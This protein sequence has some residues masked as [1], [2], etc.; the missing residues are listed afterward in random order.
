MT[1]Y[2]DTIKRLTFHQTLLKDNDLIKFKSVLLAFS[3]KAS[4]PEAN[5]ELIALFFKFSASQGLP[6]M[7]LNIAAAGP[8]PIPGT[9]LVEG[10]V[11]STS[12]WLTEDEG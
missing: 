11:A 12:G 7:N 9:D 6:K 2:H 8:L 5:D 4:L 10:D 1:T 3:G